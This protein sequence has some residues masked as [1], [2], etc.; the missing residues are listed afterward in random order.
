M[1]SGR[2]PW[3][4]QTLELELTCKGGGTVWTEVKVSFLCDQGGGV[5]GILG[6]SRDITEHRK[7]EEALRERE[8]RLR[9]IFDG[10]RD[11]IAVTKGWIRV[12]VNPAY[13]SLFGHESADEPLGKPIFDDIAPE[14]RDFVMQLEKKR[15]A[16]EPVPPFYEETAL[17]KDGTRFFA[18]VAVSSYV[19]KGEEYSC[20]ILRDITDRKKAEDEA[21]LLKHSIDVHYDGAYWIDSN[22]RLVYVNDAACKSLGYEREELIGKSLLDVNL[23]A[24]P[25]AM[26]EV[27]EQIKKGGYFLGESIQRRKDGSE[28]PVEV[29]TTYVQFDGREFACGFARDITEKKKLEGQ[30]RQAQKM[31]TIGTL[32]AGVA[33]DFKNILTAIEGFANLGIKHVEDSNKSKRYL[34]RICRA[35]ERGKDI[36]GQILT[37]SYKS[38]N[39][40]KPTELIS[41]VK[42]SVRMLRASLQPGIEIREDFRTESSF[43]RADPTQVQQVIINLATN[44]AYAMKQKRGI[45]TIEVSDFNL[46]SRNA[47]IPGM[48]AGPYLKLSISDT[49]TGMDRQTMERV[50]DPF[51]T[52]KKRTEG[53][54]LGLWVVHSI[55]KKHRGAITVRSAPGEGSTFEVFLPRFV[56]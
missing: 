29:V 6:V 9:A 38:E 44:A 39:E 33:H 53:T 19:L 47:P 41:V 15:K 7:T 27:W 4:P 24:T 54:G 14:S 17:K 5:V 36:V 18:E 40:P 35:V 45:L 25:E 12:F 37:F 22:A 3:E 43:V 20:V 11:A 50:F 1:L 28:F 8:E 16:G 23:A 52:T 49:G 31:E 46:I 21:R 42:E 30:L 56:D 13:I 55:V 48:T 51:F 10:S 26:Q 32:S 2:I 34:D